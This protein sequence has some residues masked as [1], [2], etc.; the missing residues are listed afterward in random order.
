MSRQESPIDEEKHAWSFIGGTKGTQGSIESALSKRVE[1]E[2]GVKIEKVEFVSKSCYHATL[3]DDN[4]N[5]IERQEG[6]LLSFFSFRE[7]Q[8]LLLSNPT[9]EF[10]SKHGALI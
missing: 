8:N 9:R 7:L 3:T 5:R 10:V 4:V 6:Q 1:K 2:T